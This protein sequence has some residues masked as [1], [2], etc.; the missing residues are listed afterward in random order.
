MECLEKI[1]K[2][3][4]ST[5]KLVTQATGWKTRFAKFDFI[6]TLK[7]CVTQSN[8]EYKYTSNSTPLIL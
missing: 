1:T 6:A 7:I 5:K 2:D 8:I 3:E 4:N